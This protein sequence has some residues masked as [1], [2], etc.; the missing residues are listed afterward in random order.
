MSATFRAYAVLA[1]VPLLIAVAVAGLKTGIDLER[2]RSQ[3]EIATLKQGWAESSSRAELAART[4]LETAQ[5]LG[6]VL[7]RDLLK[8]ESSLHQS[9]N[10]RREIERRTTGRVCLS[11]SAVR[12][13]NSPNHPDTRNE[14]PTPASSVA[15]ADGPAATDRDIAVWIDNA[16]REYDICRARLDALVDFEE[17]RP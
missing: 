4:R 10:R 7:T 15:A 1:L 5:A 14:L 3:A 16:R 12:L 8:T 2:K 17:R 6:D 13:L 11:A 9:E